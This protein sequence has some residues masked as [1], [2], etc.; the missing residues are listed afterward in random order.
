MLVRVNHMPL[1]SLL[2]CRGRVAP[3]FHPGL[4][5]GCIGC[6]TC[7]ILQCIYRLVFMFSFLPAFLF[8]DLSECGRLLC[9]V[10]VDEPG[11]CV[12][13]GS[14][15]LHFLGFYC[16]PLLRGGKRT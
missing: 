2:L 1:L 15:L 3:L 13:S 16:L 12:A 14:T 6:V 11:I 9:P 8:L 10:R 4:S 7:S 5:E